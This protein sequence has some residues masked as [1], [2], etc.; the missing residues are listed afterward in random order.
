MGFDVGGHFGFHGLEEHLKCSLT[1]HFIQGRAFLSIHEL[2]VELTCC[3]QQLHTGSWRI[4]LVPF[5]ETIELIPQSSGYAAFPQP[6]IHNFWL[7][8]FGPAPTPEGPFCNGPS[9]SLGSGKVPGAVFCVLA[10]CSLLA[11]RGH[12]YA[13]VFMLE[14]VGEVS[15]AGGGAGDSK[16]LWIL[17][18]S[19]LEIR[20]WIERIGGFCSWRRGL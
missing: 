14:G 13:S 15:G 10:E 18:L 3:S 19:F 1:Q 20:D 9:P 17:G 11:S 12:L 2:G 7:Y 4:L 6:L 5:Q 8:L 16:P